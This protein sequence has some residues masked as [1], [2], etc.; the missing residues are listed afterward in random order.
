MKRREQYRFLC[1]SQVDPTVKV[2]SIAKLRRISMGRTVSAIYV[3]AL[4]KTK[5]ANLI[6]EAERISKVSLSLKWTQQSRLFLSL[7]RR[8]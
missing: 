2:I 5:K 4:E 1:I 3:S 6:S 8:E 7:N